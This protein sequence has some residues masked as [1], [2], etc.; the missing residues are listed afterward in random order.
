MINR[1]E[2]MM[3]T[4]IKSNETMFADHPCQPTVNEEVVISPP[5][6]LLGRIARKEPEAFDE[7]IQ[8]FGNLVWSLARRF[9]PTQADAED[10]VQEIFLD[11]WRKAAQFNPD[12]SAES[13]FITM[14]ARRKLIDRHRKSGRTI[15]TVSMLSEWE[16]PANQSSAYAAEVTDEADKANRCLEG[17]G[18]NP[19]H[20]IRMSIHGGK[21]HAQISNE[22]SMPLGTVK[23]FARRGLIQLRQCM[24][25][26]GMDS[27]GAVS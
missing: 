10:A 24:E 13:T 15:E 18:E 16:H 26:F 9:S 25:K 8:R 21:S 11:L 7:C 2:F 6:N 17:L 1:N 12:L 20:V 22:L 4:T 3:H 19:R 5:D 14:L 23:S 27:R